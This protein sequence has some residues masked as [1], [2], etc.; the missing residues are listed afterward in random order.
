[1]LG[2]GCFDAPSFRALGLLI[3]NE[4]RD[5]IGAP[6]QGRLIGGKAGLRDAHVSGHH[7]RHPATSLHMF[8]Q[9]QIGKL[10]ISDHLHRRANPERGCQAGRS[11]ASKTTLSLRADSRELSCATVVIQAS[12]S[13]STEFLPILTRCPRGLKKKDTIEGGW[14]TWELVVAA[15]E[16][17]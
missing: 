3:Q 9:P 2:R 1:M 17:G 8:R 10:A 7:H 6:S 14:P 12:G 13:G 11:R 15:Q 16:P 4:N 5:A